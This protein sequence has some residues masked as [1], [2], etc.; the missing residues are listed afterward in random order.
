VYE[1]STEQFEEF[2]A[3]A[4]DSIPEEFAKRIENVA[5]LVEDDAKDANLF[6]LYEG[7]P[8]TQRVNRSGAMPDRITIFQNAISR[9]CFTE[10]QV[11]NLVRETVVHELGHYFGMSDDKLRALGW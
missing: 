9:A 6:G 1:V 4:L 7:T 5:F 3:D 11:R 2:V 8:L 10:L